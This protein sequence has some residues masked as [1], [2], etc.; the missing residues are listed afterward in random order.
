M[1][2]NKIVTFLPS[3][4]A[5]KL[6][7]G[8]F[9]GG[10]STLSK[11]R[12]VCVRAYFVCRPVMDATKALAQRLRRRNSRWREKKGGAT[13]STTS[14]TP[15]AVA[16]GDPPASA[17]APVTAPET[18]KASLTVAPLKANVEIPSPGSDVSP[19]SQVPP[20]Q[21][22]VEKRDPEKGNEDPTAETAASY[23]TVKV[24]EDIP[25]TDAPA[26]K[27]TFAIPT[28]E[29]KEDGC[30]L[31]AECDSKEL[32]TTMSSTS[33]SIVVSPR[34][35]Q[36]DEKEE[37][38]DE[39]VG[40]SSTVSISGGGGSRHSSIASVAFRL[41]DESLPQGRA[42]RHR[43]SLPPS[44]RFRKHV[45]F[46]N[47]TL[48]EPTK[49]NFPSYTL[50]VRHLGY[51][52]N[53]RRSRTFMVGIDDH[54][55]SDEA[56]Q[57]LFG[58]FVDDGDEIVCVRVVEKD[59]RQLEADKRQANFQKEANAEVERIKAKCGDSKAISIVLEYAV[60]KL[61][62]TFQRLIQ[63]HQ[64]S[65]LI[66]GTRG[67]TLGGFQGLMATRNS[68]SKYCLQ[69]SPVPVV[70]VR[71]DEKRQ[72]KREKRD[73]DPEKWSYRQMLQANQGIHEADSDSAVDWQI[74]SKLSADEEAGKVARAL[75]LP[76]K[77]DPTLKRYKPERQRSSLSV[78][79]TLGDAGR[80]ISTPTITPTASAANSEDEGSGDED[81][82]GEGEFEATSGAKLLQAQKLELEEKQKE[83]E[84]K[85]RLHE[86][87]VGEAAALLKHKPDD[88][89]EDDDEDDEEGGGAVTT[90]S[91]D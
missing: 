47:V 16:A 72:K 89:E 27:I 28:K 3:T 50:V 48:G 9:D 63:L 41:P 20:K 76:A 53:Q 33:P 5:T 74:E 77:F 57:W 69:Y 67:R 1:V 55:Y 65:M 32:D 90:T 37:D 79:T 59:V 17:P 75:G 22:H 44:S 31:N 82:E 7:L 42:R 91:A 21:G 11:P 84:K 25:N 66:V 46:N 62:A 61:H 15:A 19:T 36:D 86:M 49:H 24:T 73:N 51:A 23:F 70:V 38:E 8:S 83:Q 18:E 34:T 45:T 35:S 78:S 60:G 80:L 40:R 64:P 87:E 58:K 14:N 6:D 12:C 39:D 54:E 81:E 13:R 10:R 52:S 2:A 56:L 26:S 4:S 29:E 30:G 68:F 88:E 71:P 85:E 43:S